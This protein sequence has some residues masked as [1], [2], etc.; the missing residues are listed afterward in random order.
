LHGA[1]NI[2]VKYGIRRTKCCQH[3]TYQIKATAFYL[4]LVRNLHI[5]SRFRWL[6]RVRNSR[7]PFLS[8]WHIIRVTSNHFSSW[9]LLSATIDSIISRVTPSQPQTI[10]TYQQVLVFRYFFPLYPHCKTAIIRGYLP[11]YVKTFL[12]R[13]MRPAGRTLIHW[14]RLV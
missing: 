9:S 13:L 14:L 3:Y 10:V 4:V 7:G 6:S 1:P 11:F 8:S 2:A 12:Y 5:F